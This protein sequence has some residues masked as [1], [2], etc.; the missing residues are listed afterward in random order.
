[1]ASAALRSAT[2]EAGNV[3][4][5]VKPWGTPAYTSLLTRTLFIN[6][7][8]NGYTQQIPVQ[9]NMP[10]LHLVMDPIQQFG[11]LE[12]EMCEG[13]CTSARQ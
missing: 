8:W 12:S 2:S 13:G 11:R 4:N 10:N 7:T 3:G 6:K 9:Y 5:S 1:M